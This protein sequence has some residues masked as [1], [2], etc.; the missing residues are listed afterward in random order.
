MFL[1]N[2]LFTA[3]M[4]RADGGSGLAVTAA[5]AG[6]FADVRLY[7]VKNRHQSFAVG[8]QAVVYA[9]GTSP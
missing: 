2:I 7:I 3:G 1:T 4:L 8:G 5:V 6:V 9:G